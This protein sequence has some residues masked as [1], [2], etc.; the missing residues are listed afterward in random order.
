MP[1]RVRVKA[2]RGEDAT[3]VV[4]VV[5]GMVWLSISPHFTWEAIMTPGTV[6]EVMRVLEK[7]RDEANRP[8]QHS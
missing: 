3:I 1:R 7:A 5:Q 6:D 2:M 8:P 4:R